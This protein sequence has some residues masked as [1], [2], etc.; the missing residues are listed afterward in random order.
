VIDRWTLSAALKSVALCAAVAA[1]HIGLRGVGLG[2]RL[3]LDFAAYTA[4]A[5]AIGIV[6]PEDVRALARL[7]RTRTA[8][9]ARE[10]AQ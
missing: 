9:S 3:V 10:T 5:V 7:V 8:R 6:R 2:G 1:L 4:S